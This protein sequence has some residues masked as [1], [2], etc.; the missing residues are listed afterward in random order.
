MTVFLKT[1]GTETKLENKIVS[2]KTEPEVF[3]PQCLRMQK[4]LEKEPLKTGSRISK[5]KNWNKDRKEGR[6]WVWWLTHL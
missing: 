4:Q 6:G 3:V 1:T 5:K 2:T